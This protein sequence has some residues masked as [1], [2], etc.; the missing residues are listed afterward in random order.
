MRDV[1]HQDDISANQ[2]AEIFHILLDYMH[3]H[4]PGNAYLKND[5]KVEKM[6]IELTVATML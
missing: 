4:L 5:K 2:T 1:Y 3:N 6:K